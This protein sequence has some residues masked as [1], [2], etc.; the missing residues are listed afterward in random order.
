MTKLN[1]VPEQS[2]DFIFTSIAEEQGFVGSIG[3]VILF[4]IIILRCFAIAEKRDLNLLKDFVIVSEA[5]YFS[6][7]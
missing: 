6:I 7:L 1:Y 4:T 2:T 5:L 3:I